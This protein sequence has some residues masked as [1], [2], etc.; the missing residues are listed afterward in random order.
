MPIRWLCAPNRAGYQ[1]EGLR[2]SS[3]FGNYIHEQGPNHGW[4][5]TEERAWQAHEGENSDKQ[6]S[7]IYIEQKSVWRSLHAISLVREIKLG[8]TDGI[9]PQ[10]RS[11]RGESNNHVI[12]HKGARSDGPFTWGATCHSI[13][14]QIPVFPLSCSLISL[15]P[16]QEWVMLRWEPCSWS[17]CISKA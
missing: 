6:S 15:F 13:D 2:V 11:K 5:S 16:L 7:T 9:E 12:F 4:W 1:E 8:K 17:F 3:C 14:T 10:E